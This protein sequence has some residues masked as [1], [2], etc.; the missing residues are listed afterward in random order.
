LAAAGA[1]D[2][3]GEDAAAGVEL[4]SEAPAAGSPL[5]VAGVGSEA[6]GPADEA[7]EP[8][9]LGRAADAK[10]GFCAQAL[11]G[12]TAAGEAGAGDSVPDRRELGREDG[13]LAPR[14]SEDG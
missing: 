7:T 13:P 8:A 3:A 1:R 14:L 11:G 5:M 4:C 12:G 2:G 6:V 10:L 9:E